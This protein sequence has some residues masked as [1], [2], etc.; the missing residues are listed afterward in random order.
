MRIFKSCILIIIAVFT[1]QCSTEKNTTIH[2]GFHN[3]HAKYNGYFNANE[4][5]KETYNEFL[6]SRKE[7]YNSI[8][9]VFPTPN[10]VESKSWYAPMDTAYRKCELVIYKHRMPH[11]KKGRNRNKE[12]CKY[13][14]DNWMTM[15]RTRY[16]KKDFPKALKIFQYVENHYKIEDNFYR[17]IFWQAKVLIEMKAYDEAEDILL[18]ILAKNEEQLKNLKKDSKLK[19]KDK[20]ILALNYENRID[21][22][23]NKEPLISNQILSQVYPTLADLYIKSDFTKKAIENL[24]TA[25]EDKQKK[26]FKTRL[27]FILA[28]LYHEE[29]NY[30]ASVYYQ[31]VVERNPEYEMAFQAKINRALSFS[32][33]DSKSIKAQLLKMLKDDKNIEFFDQIY[34][35]LAEIEFKN[36]NDELGKQQLQK[37]INLS[38]SNLP[39]KIKSMKRMGDLYFDKSQYIKSYFYYDSIKQIPLN[40]YKFKDL[41][42]K[43]HKLL[44]TIFI[45]RATIDMND[46]IIAICSLD[47]KERRD[48]IYQAVDLVIAK[49]SNNSESTLLALS[50]LNKTPTNNTSSQSFFIWDQSSLK[51]GKIEFDKKWGKMSLEDNWRR[52]SKSN[53]FFD[54]TEASESDFSNTDLFDELSQNLPCDNDELLSSMKDSILTSLFNLGLIHHYETKNLERSAK[55]FKRIADN[56]QPKIQSI[57]SIYELYIIYKVLGAQKS[58]LEMKQLLLDNYPN[59]KYAKLLL[60]G[61]T[62]S[63]ESLAMKKENMEYSKLFS[64]YKA[65]KYINT[66]EACSNKMK[67][68]TNPLFCQYGLLKAYSLKKNNDTLNN[69]TKLISTLKSI[70]KQCLGTEFADQAISVLNDL[71]VKTAENLNQ[72]EKWDFTYNPDTLHYFILIAPKDGFSINSAKNNTANFNSSN[73]SELKL[74]VSS[75]FLNTSDQMIIVKYF[76]NSKKALDYLLAFKANKGKIKSY[77]N[78]D[79]FIINPKNLRELYIEKNTTNYLDFFKQFYE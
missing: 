18:N 31:Q 5:I 60:G 16:F 41:V 53:T 63:D 67:D 20:L 7:N 48:K 59:S 11:T 3:L 15:G 66:I 79:F 39:Q 22:L 9:P 64:G 73:F 21:Y 10:E 44:S 34:Y 23:E 40:D 36:K 76:K 43:K 54:E 24:E 75:T 14:D 13:I 69:N 50:S 29:N 68:T 8:L 70:V 56:F 35:A 47:P 38:V 78:E 58:S 74:K 61:K 6:N 57:A 4:I 30:K 55:Y 71:K 27:I 17:S 49:R 65:G 33:D 12:W 2:R 46:S 62:L 37:S 51:R 77:K 19:L 32:G 28:Q 42:E 72:K 52:S 45:N 1:L 26:K 25:I